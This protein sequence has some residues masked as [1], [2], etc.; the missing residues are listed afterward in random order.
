MVNA[1]LRM[2][3]TFLTVT[4]TVTGGV[5]GLS[6]LRLD[7]HHVTAVASGEAA[8]E[9]LRRQSFDVVLSD[10]G[11]GPGMDGWQLPGTCAAACQRSG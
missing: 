9:H 11:L 5:I 10:L 1:A 7:G 2:P 8:L 3:D 4:R 6:V